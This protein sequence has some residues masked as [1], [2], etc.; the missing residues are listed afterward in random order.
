MNG[1]DD[2]VLSLLVVLP[3]AAAVALILWP[4]DQ[5]RR[6]KWFSAGVAL[7]STALVA[8]VL[9]RFDYTDGPQYQFISETAWLDQLGIGFDLGV[10]GIAVAMLALT[11]IAFPAAILIGWNIDARSKDYLILLNLLVGGVYGTFVSIDLF[12]LFFFYEI[13]VLPMYLLIAYWGSSTSFP[14]FTRLKEYSAMKLVLF[15]VGGSVLVWISIIAM[16][17][18]SDLDTFSLIELQGTGFDE[19]FQDWVFPLLMLGFGLLG[20]L[21]PLHT[22]SPDGH[23][24]APTSVSMLHAGVLMKLG[25]FGVIRV[26]IQTMPEG[27]EAWAPLLLGLGAINVIYGSIAAMS[28]TD[29]KYVI[30]YS[31]VS[32]M[33]YV[34]LGLAT[35]HTLGVTGA[36]LQMFSHGIMTALMFT[37]AGAVYGSSHTRDI[38]TL[39]G[40]AKVMPVG[41]FFFAVAGF[42]SLGLPGFSGF[43]AE[44]LVFLGLFQTYPWIGALGVIGAAITAVY[45]LRLLAKVYFG[46]TDRRWENLPDLKLNEKLVAGTLALTLLIVGLVPFY[47]IDIIREGVR[48]IPAVTG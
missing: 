4:G 39:T 34:F 10:D 43:V 44:L 2:S 19:S 17:I 40:L 8:W 37:L 30:G 29:L 15:L 38:R 12:F 48:H 16:Y 32:H 18:E 26:G 33:G 42:A 13:A 23:V 45:M 3:F 41:A 6:M 11:A 22:W 21:W 35:L 47:L 5:L 14:R 36:V 9:L 28:Q 25:A 20:G 27:A 46:E 7:A 24:S 31:S 1:L